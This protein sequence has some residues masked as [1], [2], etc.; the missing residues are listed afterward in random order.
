[1]PAKK[2][3]TFT[4]RKRSTKY[5]RRKQFRKSGYKRT[6]PMYS[7]I[8]GLP[9]TKTVNMPYHME[10]TTSTAGIHYNT[11]RSNSIYDPDYTGGGHQPRSHDQY[12]AYYKYYRVLST[13][14]R[15]T[16]YWDTIPSQSHCVGIYVDDNGTFAYSSSLDLYEKS[17]TRYTKPLLPSSLAKTSVYRK[18]NMSRMSNKALKDQRTE[19]NSNPSLDGPLIHIWTLPNNTGALTYGAVR[20]HVAMVFRVQMFEPLDITG[21]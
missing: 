16:F 12:A 5:G 6:Y 1:M 19:F 18:L 3:T 8:C 7:S 20:V 9:T 17:G 4:K 2:K 14:I 11:F 21:S 10:F 15:A 13:S